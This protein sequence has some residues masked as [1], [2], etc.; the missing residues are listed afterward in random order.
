VPVKAIYF[1]TYAR[2]LDDSWFILPPKFELPA[3]IRIVALSDPNAH[4]VRPI[5]VLEFAATWVDQL[6]R[7]PP[8]WPS[9][10]VKAEKVNF[11]GDRF[12]ITV[13][14]GG[15][16]RFHLDKGKPIVIYTTDADVE[17][18]KEAVLTDAFRLQ[19]HPVDS[20]TLSPQ[21]W[22]DR[23][24]EPLEMQLHAPTFRVPKEYRIHPKYK[25][26]LSLGGGLALMVGSLHYAQDSG[27]ALGIW[28]IFLLGC[29]LTTFG[30]LDLLF[31]RW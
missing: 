26:L 16:V 1:S 27:G 25:A 6:A 19:D 21:F 24:E 18:I 17:A 10:P 31:S 2:G 4:G 11:D 28:W 23:M 14:D 3:V 13:V 12:S 8:E 5:Q 29:T 7:T 20:K 9:G 15:V 22:V 30:L